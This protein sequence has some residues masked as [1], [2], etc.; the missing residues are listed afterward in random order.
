MNENEKEVIRNEI[1]PK[2]RSGNVTLFLGAGYSLGAKAKKGGIPSSGELVKRICSETEK[3][4]L[5]DKI[6]LSD[7]F[8]YGERKIEN[9]EDFLKEN[10]E[11]VEA[12]N[13][14]VKVFEYWWRAVFT[15]NIDSVP[16]YSLL[17]IRDGIKYPLYQIY[18]FKDR[19]PLSP[20][21]VEP[22]VVH[23]HGY[24]KRASEGF[25]FDNVQYADFTSAEPDWLRECALHVYHGSCLFVGSKFNESDI[26]YSIR[27][28]ESFDSDDRSDSWIVLK[29]VDDISRDNYIERGI[30]P[31]E[32][33]AEEFFE[34]L[35]NHL[36]YVSPKK[37]MKQKAP[38]LDDSERTA[39]SSWFYQNFLNIGVELE[40]ASVEKG[41]ESFFYEGDYPSWYYVSRQVPA[42]MTASIFLEKILSD[43]ISSED[44][45]RL[46]SVVGKIGAGKTTACMSAVAKIARIEK[47]VYWHF[48]ID[49]IDIE[50][51]WSILKNA[52]GA[53]FLVIDAAAEHFY[54]INEL[55]KRVNQDSIG[56]RL[57]VV[58]EER[59][60]NFNRN[61]RHLYDVVDQ[62]WKEVRVSDLTESDAEKLLD[63][64]YKVGVSFPKL[65]GL[66]RGAS[67]SKLISVDHGYRGDLLATLHDLSSNVALNKK[68]YSEFLEIENN[69][70][71]LIY[72]TISILSADRLH[73]PVSYLS[74][75]HNVGI[76]RVMGIIQKDLKGKVYYD[77]RNFTVS[78]RGHSISEYQIKNIFSK[79]DL[80]GSIVG[81]LQC[82][83]KKFDIQD[84]R[85][86]PISYRIYKAIVSHK[87]L[88]GV[89]FSGKDNEK[90]IHSVYSE[91]QRYFSHDGVFWLQYGKFL[92]SVDELD[93]AVH[94]FRKGLSLYPGS[95]QICHALGQILIKRF[96]KGG[97]L[98]VQDF[99]EGVRILELEIKSRGNHDPFP[100]CSLI[101]GILGVV[102]MD[103]EVENNVALLKEYATE[104][105]KYHKKDTRFAAL[106]TKVAAL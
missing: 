98:E 14:Q 60:Y 9:F 56:A 46:V 34:E 101:E 23:I 1:A 54:A 52:K 85:K 45:A 95:F 94:C 104:G 76:P 83:A 13:W 64:A 59:T 27:R 96:S 81:L 10:F 11:C 86:H 62:Q 93:Q 29:T 3:N 7:A 78:S 97:C 26:E 28:R 41:V 102:S 82:V 6:S 25:V 100:Y 80:K 70:A 61:K 35:F 43:F 42:Q 47:N 51:V 12:E 65:G 15:T 77:R 49:G 71:R 84:I 4:E 73:L 16:E 53:F 63:S 37:F 72:I 38:Y 58:F 88:S 103:Y 32:A 90:I 106:F 66:D 91:A 22:P 48:G 105:L 20:L 21:V 19:K 57:C 87:Y 79:D 74:E 5:A 67:I 2:V 89:L 40:K 24:V 33:T 44:K 50:H 92:E 99:D 55:I 75:V 31:I 39:A 69:E 68:L 36:N 30:Y 18:N 17:A 8:S